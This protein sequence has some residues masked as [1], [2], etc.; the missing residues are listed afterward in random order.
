MM[1][2]VR[3]T[4]V[5]GWTRLRGLLEDLYPRPLKAK[6]TP[7]NDKPGSSPTKDPG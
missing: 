5:F 3:H 7:G 4:P 1:D 2:D 6:P